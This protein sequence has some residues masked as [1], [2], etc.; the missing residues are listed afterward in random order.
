METKETWYSPASYQ[1]KVSGKIGDQWTSFFEDLDCKYENGT[2]TISG[3][4]VDQ[5]ALHGVL[6]RIRD[7]GLQLIS[8][9]RIETEYSTIKQK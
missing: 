7:I 8:V 5:S 6:N 3:T 9:N 1:V 4:V 2:T